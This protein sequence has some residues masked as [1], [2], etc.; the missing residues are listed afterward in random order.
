MA[1][2]GAGDGSAAA[3]GGATSTS[4]A[5][6]VGF[7]TAVGA[8]NLAPERSRMVAIDGGGAGSGGGVAVMVSSGCV[9]TDTG[10][11]AISGAVSGTGIANVRSAT[12]WGAGLRG[13]LGPGPP[14]AIGSGA[15]AF[16]LDG[17]A[18]GFVAAGLIK[19]AGASTGLIGCDLGAALCAAGAASRC[20]AA[21]V[22]FS[23]RRGGSS[24]RFSLICT[25]Y[26]NRVCIATDRATIHQKIGRNAG[27][28][29]AATIILVRLR[30]SRFWSALAPAYARHS[31]PSLLPAGNADLC[32][33]IARS[34]LR[35]D[36]V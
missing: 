15:D 12:G 9:A 26:K 2:S 20:G 7:S 16:F 25:P 10:L 11:G 6:R 32:R 1:G 19:G 21:M 3:K 8:R 24:T 35:F 18:A 31:P 36:P 29:S 33:A 17:L 22:A 28:L 14:R 13:G 27:K 4:S 23:V 30:R 34:S 5:G